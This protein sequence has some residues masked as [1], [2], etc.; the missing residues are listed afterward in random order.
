MLV[1]A[2][3][4]FMGNGIQYNSRQPTHSPPQQQHDVDMG[5]ANSQMLDSIVSG[6]NCMLA[7]LPQNY[8]TRSAET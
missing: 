1:R 4:K 3:L 8:L 6:S 2:H 5:N 7:L